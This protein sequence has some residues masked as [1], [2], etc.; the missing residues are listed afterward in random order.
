M[1]TSVTTTDVQHAQTV[2]SSPALIRL[3][4]EIDD[5]GPLPPRA[6]TR[7]LADVPEEHLRHCADQARALGLV[8][9]QPGAGLSLTASGEELADVYDALARWARRHSYPA[10]VCDF[11]GRIQHTLALLAQPPAGPSK[12]D[13]RRR[14]DGVPGSAE[15]GADFVRL[16]RLFQEW[17]RTNPQVVGVADP[18]A[19]A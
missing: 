2:L 19:A 4:S 17:L 3:I 11:T 13:P 18:E 7:T 5:N 12:G 9:V 6:L 8:H 10:P 14:A 15:D 1:T 16:S